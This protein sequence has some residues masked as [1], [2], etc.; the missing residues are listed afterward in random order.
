[1]EKYKEPQ[2]QIKSLDE[3]RKESMERESEKDVGNQAF[4]GANEQFLSML[5]TIENQDKIFGGN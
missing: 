1:M 4:R 2:V 3:A 5:K